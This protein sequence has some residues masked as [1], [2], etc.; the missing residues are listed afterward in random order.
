MSNN[1]V[2]V[3]ANSVCDWKTV[4]WR[5][6]KKFFWKK[7]KKSEAKLYSSISIRIKKTR[8]LERKKRQIFDWKWK[9]NRRRKECI[10]NLV[11]ST[12]CKYRTV[13]KFEA[14]ASCCFGLLFCMVHSYSPCVHIY[15]HCVCIG[16]V[17][18]SKIDGKQFIDVTVCRTVLAR[19]IDAI[20]QFSMQ[21]GYWFKTFINNTT[22]KTKSLQVIFGCNLIARRL[23]CN[24][25]QSINANVMHSKF[26]FH[27]ILDHCCFFL[28]IAVI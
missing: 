3:T 14:F 2:T 19:Q 13:V 20:T 10:S 7:R 12:E 8:N 5:V 15:I 26:F 22:R 1:T 18:Q 4:G 6:K 28:L 21:N 24:P 16:N 11:S 23:K 25:H 9:K 17:K 27:P